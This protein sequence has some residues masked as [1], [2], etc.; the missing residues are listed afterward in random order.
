MLG[1]NGSTPQRQCW[2]FPSTPPGQPQ[3]HY[4]IPLHSNCYHFGEGWK[5]PEHSRFFLQFGILL[6]HA[7]DPSHIFIG[8]VRPCMFNELLDKGWRDLDVSRFLLVLFLFAS[9]FPVIR[10]LEQL[11]WERT[12]PLSSSLLEA[13]AF[14]WST[15]LAALS[16]ALVSSNAI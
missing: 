4:L 11:A 5:A 12:R 13:C 8:T 3:E 16:I 6:N 15:T 10:W 2:C 1:E 14:S 9:D 7:S